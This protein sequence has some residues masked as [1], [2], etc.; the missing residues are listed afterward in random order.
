LR[1]WVDFA[2]D[3]HC[4]PLRRTLAVCFRDLFLG[5]LERVAFVRHLP[6]EVLATSEGRLAPQSLG[7]STPLLPVTRG[8]P[9]FCGGIRVCWLVGRRV[10]SD[11]DAFLELVL[12]PV[13]K[14]EPLVPGHWPE[15]YVR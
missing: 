5:H 1:E 8:M 11:R 3:G 6:S 2:P 9:R 14:G 12:P 7:L 15:G 4:P 13:R 10:V